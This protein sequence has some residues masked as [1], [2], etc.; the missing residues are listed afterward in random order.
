MDIGADLSAGFERFDKHDDSEADH[1]TSLLKTIIDWEKRE[2]KR[3]DAHLVTWRGMMTKVSM[4]V[5][6]N[7][8][9]RQCTDS[10]LDI[11]LSV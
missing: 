9:L 8:R 2:G 3:L 11:K 10:N 5:S 4:P 1:L 7:C 6:R